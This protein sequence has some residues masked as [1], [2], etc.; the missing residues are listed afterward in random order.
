MGRV[1]GQLQ[2]LHQGQRRV[3]HRLLAGDGEG[4]GGH[5]PGGQGQPPPVLGAAAHGGH[6]LHREI[7][8]NEL[9]LIPPLGDVGDAR[10]GR[11]RPARTSSRNC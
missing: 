3:Q 4:Q 7:L 2:V 8:D 10:L 11:R 5:L 1:H 6:G 9:Q